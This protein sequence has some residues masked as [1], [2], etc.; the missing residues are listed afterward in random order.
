MNIKK[1]NI[2]GKILD[3]D[4]AYYSIDEVTFHSGKPHSPSRLC[5]TSGDRSET[6][7][8]GESWV[9][10]S[11]WDFCEECWKKGSI[12]IVKLVDEKI[13]EK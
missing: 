4:S 9:T 7:E 13:K 10:Y 8:H 12:D 1:C 2:C 11:D 6:V 3:L 5:F